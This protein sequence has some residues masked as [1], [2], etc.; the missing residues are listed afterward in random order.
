MDSWEQEHVPMCLTRESRS[1]RER[2]RKSRSKMKQKNHKI[3]HLR[4]LI[5][6]KG[7]FF[8]DEEQSVSIIPACYT[9]PRTSS[10]AK[11]HVLR[12]KQN[13]KKKTIQQRCTKLRSLDGNRDVILG[14]SSLGPLPRLL[15][16][17]T[18]KKHQER[19]E[20]SK[21]NSN[22]NWPPRSYRILLKEKKS[23]A[24]DPAETNHDP[25]R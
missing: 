1:P 17:R 6:K 2:K 25:I 15:R 11:E 16:T 7:S 12:S 10:F 14:S 9:F 8:T 4:R 22:G 20:G 23:R 13:S 18:K 24:K 5:A 3:S 21:Q 19:E